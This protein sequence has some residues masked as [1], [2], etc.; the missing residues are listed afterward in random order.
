MS[1]QGRPV[2]AC[3]GLDICRELRFQDTSYRARFASIS[4]SLARRCS[5]DGWV[6]KIS[7]TEPRLIAG[8]NISVFPA[9]TWRRS[10]SGIRCIRPLIL[11]NAEASL[12]GWPVMIA[13]PRS[14]EYSR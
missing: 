9:S 10:W 11:T 3:D 13:E 2:V 8:K 5:R 12:E 7:E 1:P 14:A 4:W 6:E